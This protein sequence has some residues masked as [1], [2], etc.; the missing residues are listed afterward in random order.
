MD[1]QNHVFILLIVENGRLAV[2]LV[3]P[4][5]SNSLITLITDGISSHFS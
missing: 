5:T 1:D 2:A 3:D 4:I